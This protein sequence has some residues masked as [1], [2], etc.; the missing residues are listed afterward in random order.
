MGMR[1]EKLSG[2]RSGPEEYSNGR[3]MLLKRSMVGLRQAE[4]GSD[5]EDFLAKT[6]SE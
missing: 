6:H 2:I 3:Q 4:R 1:M 5:L